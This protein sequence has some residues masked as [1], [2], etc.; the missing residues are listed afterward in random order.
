ML[1][2]GYTCNRERNAEKSVG[3]IAA[4]LT[5]LLYFR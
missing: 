2:A 4:D 1:I 3:G 5:G